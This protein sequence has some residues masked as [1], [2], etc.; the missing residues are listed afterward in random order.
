MQITEIIHQ[1]TFQLMD[2]MTAPIVPTYCLYGY[3]ISTLISMQYPEDLAGHGPNYI[4]EPGVRDMSDLG[5]GTVP[6]QSLQECK[7]WISQ[8]A[9]Q[10]NCKV[11]TVL[12]LSLSRFHYYGASHHPLSSCR[13]TTSRS[14]AL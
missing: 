6:L 10:V 1:E 13:S 2:K 5:D 4:P 3:N 11:T 12:S 8:G 14:T 9:T 7:T